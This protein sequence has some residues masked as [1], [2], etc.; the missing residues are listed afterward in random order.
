M[1]RFSSCRGQRGFTLIELLVVIAII[2]ILIALLLPAVQKVREAAQRA[3]CQSNL[4]QICLA[5]INAADTNRGALPGT[6]SHY[7]NASWQAV[8]GFGSPFF[9]ILPFIE[10]GNLYKS[11]YTPPGQDGHV[12]AGGYSAW[13]PNAYNGPVPQVYICPADPSVRNG[14]NSGA[15]NWGVT[16]YAANYQ[17]FQW[18][19]D[20]A[21][22][23][24]LRRY[25]ASIVDGTSNT[26]FYTER[27]AVQTTNPWTWWYGGNTWWEWA[28]KF[29]NDITGP[30]SL[31]LVQPSVPY[32]DSNK[33]NSQQTGVNSSICQWLPT[34]PHTAG[35][36]AALGDGSVRFVA[37]G[38]SGT[39]WWAACTPQGGET[40]GND[41]N[42]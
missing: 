6:I 29:A 24:G 37:Q 9:H 42:Q 31:F 32:C 38:I 19:A 27:I 17:V 35:I 23:D 13:N 16:S 21:W 14:G 22:G 4:K 11:T 34:S 41:W 36:N 8:D 2:A 30:S 3:Q 18:G 28:P 26:I 5:T 33:T 39:T 7:P 12:P 15:G 40:L 20:P 25:P 10:Q 1:F